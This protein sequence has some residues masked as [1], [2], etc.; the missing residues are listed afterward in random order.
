MTKTTIHR[1]NE[2]KRLSQNI[3]R[4]P[5]LNEYNTIDCP[6]AIHG[7]DSRQRSKFSAEE[8]FYI[9]TEHATCLFTEEI[10]DSI[11]YRTNIF[12]PFM[13]YI[14][15]GKAFNS[16]PTKCPCKLKILCVCK[17]LS[18]TISDIPETVLSASLSF[19]YPSFLS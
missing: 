17:D 3:L 10:K 18:T 19:G 7:Y 14:P 4:Q 16:V 11:I 9:F 1:N 5:L 6:H 8:S 2:S 13:M 15:I 12:F